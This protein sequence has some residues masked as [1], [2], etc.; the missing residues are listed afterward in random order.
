MTKLDE[1]VEAAL[2]AV[3]KQTDPNGGI[4]QEMDMKAAIQAAAPAIIPPQTKSGEITEKGVGIFSPDYE[5]G[6]NACR[7]AILKNTEIE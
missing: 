1:A 4:Y 5:D 2:A 6:Y 3:W 7:A